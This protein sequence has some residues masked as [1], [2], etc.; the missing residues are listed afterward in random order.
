MGVRR[1]L[2]VLVVLLWTAFL[3]PACE[4]DQGLPPDLEARI[5]R[6]IELAVGC[7]DRRERL[8]PERLWMLMRAQERL[9]HERLGPVLERLKRNIRNDP[10]A[11][12]VDPDAPRS[13]WAASRGPM[14][15]LREP[16]RS[17]AMLMS[18]SVGCRNG[19]RPSPKLLEYMNGDYSGYVLTHQ[20][21]AIEWARSVGCEVPDEWQSRRGLLVDRLLDELRQD[22]RFTDL[23]AERVAMVALGGRV[24]ALRPRWVA[25]LLDSQREDGC[26]K[27]PR[28][29]VTISLFGN[30]ITFSGEDKQLTHASTMAVYALA[31]AG[32]H[33][34]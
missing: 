25:Q 2:D 23:F 20:L 29:E 16:L 27:A 26:W 32:E 22:D 21:L 14:E 7:F 31:R 5:E 34:R 12:L 3:L 24:D 11:G 15:R 17:F 6:A 8:E 1:G 9:G 28:E 30:S 18:D 13:S 10:M 19:G 4:R 33:A